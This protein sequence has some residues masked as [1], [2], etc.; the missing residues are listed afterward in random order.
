M[1]NVRRPYLIC[2][3]SLLNR[4]Y[5]QVSGSVR[6][7]VRVR[8]SVSVTA[9]ARVSARV[10]VGIRIGFRRNHS[11]WSTFTP[12]RNHSLCLVITTMIV[13]NEKVQ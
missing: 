1:V 9:R 8:V 3:D 11:W 2:I 12:R 10:T 4:R 5:L 7:S 13:A 6:V